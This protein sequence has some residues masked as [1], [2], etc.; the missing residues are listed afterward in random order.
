VNS[1]LAQPHDVACERAKGSV[2]RTIVE[3]VI[4]DEPPGLGLGP[5]E[6]YQTRMQGT[7]ICRANFDDMVRRAR[8]DALPSNIREGP[9]AGFRGAFPEVARLN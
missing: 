3:G 1:S 5:W 6:L 9:Q 7:M 2:T 4:L 8:D